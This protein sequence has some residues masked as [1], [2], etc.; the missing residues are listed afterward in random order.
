MAGTLYVATWNGR[1]VWVDGSKLVIP[2]VINGDPP[3]DVLLGV[4]VSRLDQ[5]TTSFNNAVAEVLMDELRT[6]HEL[7]EWRAARE[8]GMQA[9]MRPKRRRGPKPVQPG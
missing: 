8:L 9:A 7:A 5:F 3:K 2:A 6:A 4:Y 1:G